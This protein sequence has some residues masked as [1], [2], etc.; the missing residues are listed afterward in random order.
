MDRGNATT[1]A[2]IDDDDEVRDVLQVLLEDAGHTVETYRSGSDFL[3]NARLEELGCMVVDQRMPDMSGVAVISA[4][5]DKGLS[6]P[7]LLITGAS[8]P[9]VA[10][11]AETIGAMTLLQKPLS[12]QEL[13]RF[14]S[15]SIG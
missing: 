8:D 12:P 9:E 10:R 14:V 15:F 13:L 1:V 3:T 2:I 6:I 11:A 4:V 5:A 7:S